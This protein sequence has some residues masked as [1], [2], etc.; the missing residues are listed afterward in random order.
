MVCVF[1]R[2]L[3]K[4][5]LFTTL[6]FIL[7]VSSENICPSIQQSTQ[8]FYIPNLCFQFL[9]TT[10]KNQFPNLIISFPAKPARKTDDLY[11]QLCCQKTCDQTAASLHSRYQYSTHCSVQSQCSYSVQSQ[12]SLHFTTDISTVLIIQSQYILHCQYS[13]SPTDSYIVLSTVSQL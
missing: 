8:T 13:P 4:L 6:L 7:Y 1:S 11:D 9:T 10:T 5:P 2:F 3:L 12:Y